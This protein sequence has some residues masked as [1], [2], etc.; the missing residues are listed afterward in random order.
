MGFM[1]E[2][3]PLENVDLD[4]VLLTRLTPVRE[5]RSRGWRTRAVDHATESLINSATFP[6]D[7]VRHDTVDVLMVILIM[8]LTAGCFPV[9][10]KRDVSKAFRRC[11]IRSDHLDLAY[12]VFMTEG[13]HWVAQH[14]GMPF[15]A[16][17]SVYAR[18]RVGNWLTWCFL[19]VAQLQSG[20]SWTIFQSLQG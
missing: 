5:L 10:W 12:V 15:G 20:V 11:P 2:P 14:I 8:F 3:V 7:R 13:R 16:T 4:A 18:H 1:T 6:L 17:S 9:M 19:M